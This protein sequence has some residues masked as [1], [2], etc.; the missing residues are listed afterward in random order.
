MKKSSFNFLSR[1]I[2]Y[3]FLFLFLSLSL[4]ISFSHFSLFPLNRRCSTG[5]GI[6]KFSTEFGEE[7]IREIKK[8]VNNLAAQNSSNVDKVES[9]HFRRRTNSSGT[10][11][12]P[13][14]SSGRNSSAKRCLSSMAEFPDP[15]RTRTYSGS[16]LKGTSSTARAA[17]LARLRNNQIKTGTLVSFSDL[18]RSGQSLKKRSG[19]MTNGQ[20]VA[21]NRPRSALG[22]S[23]QVTTGQLSES[24]VC[25]D[26]Q[27]VTKS[28]NDIS[29]IVY[30]Q[31]F[32][33]DEK[34]LKEKSSKEK[35]L[36]GEKSL[37]NSLPRVRESLPR[38]NVSLEM[39]AG[40]EEKDGEKIEAL[41]GENEEISEGKKAI[42]ET[43]T[44]LK[45]NEKG[46]EEKKEESVNSW[47]QIDKGV[48]GE[49]ESGDYVIHERLEQRNQLEE[50]I[51]GS[52]KYTNHS[53]SSEEEEG[54][55][56]EGRGSDGQLS[57]SDSRFGHVETEDDHPYLEIIADHSRA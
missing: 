18:T 29:T 14:P 41:M 16:T 10:K 43:V 48:H 8:T 20:P 19:S 9:G 11:P 30:S 39:K 34:S 35:S 47:N 54:K 1:R 45:Q 36:N 50:S 42:V 5:E 6:Y 38:T 22:S 33:P 2:S 7:I 12:S 49:D 56:K 24:A 37:K 40:D 25:Q 23:R 57:N 15:F 31:P 21:D 28:S 17:A 27:L 26:D 13:P 51:N 4:S 32:F 46:K 55:R 3:K 53:A 44:S 52:I